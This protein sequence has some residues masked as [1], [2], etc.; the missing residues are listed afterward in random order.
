VKDPVVANLRAQLEVI[1]KMI[2]G[3]IKGL[4]NRDQ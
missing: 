3:L 1:A 2:S 4:D